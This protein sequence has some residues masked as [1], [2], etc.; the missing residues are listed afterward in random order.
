MKPMVKAAVLFLFLCPAS[1]AMAETFGSGM[2]GDGVRE[3]Q[4]ELAEAGYFAREADGEYGSTTVKAVSLFQEDHALSVT[5]AADDETRRKISSSAGEGREGGGIILAEGNRG[6]E[7]EAC[8]NLLRSE[9][10]I[11]W[12]PDGVYGEGTVKAVAAYQRTHSLRVSG[13][14]DE[15]TFSRLH[16]KGTEKSAGISRPSRSSDTERLQR[17]LNALGYSAGEP[18]GVW[19]SRTSAAVKAFQRDHGLPQTGNPDKK[20]ENELAKDAGSS[21]GLKRGDRGNRV[22]RLQNLLTLHGFA[23]GASDGIFGA[24][25]EAQLKRFQHYH[26]L[27]EDG[28][29]GSA[30]WEALEKPPAFRGEY[31]KAFQMHSTAYTPYDSGGSGHTSMGNIAGKGHAAVDPGIIPL[32]SI[33]F[34]EGYGYAVAD[35]IGGSINGEVVDIWVDTLDQAYGWG[36]RRV[37]VYLVK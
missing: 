35:D 23:D 19:G 15:E 5:G 13:A 30:V 27:R 21:K 8:Q 9:G 4:R 2:S 34:I 6:E 22:A 10:F 17:R 1:A 28:V 36:S 18:D 25:T 16:G 20:T 37:K 29:A 32:G 12:A 3:L 26:G 31:I 14:V 33:I 7:V 24:G 11:Q